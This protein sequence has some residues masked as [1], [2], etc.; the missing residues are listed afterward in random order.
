MRASGGE[1]IP[2]KRGKGSMIYD[3]DGN[4]YIDYV[5]AYGGIIL[6]HAPKAVTHALK[7]S[8]DSGFGFGATHKLEVELAKEIKGAITFIDK[9][10]FTTSGTE[11]VMGALR[12][13][14]G[15]TRRN[16]IVKFEH[17]YHGHADSLLT[18]SGS[19]LASMGLA[20]SEGVPKDFIRHTIIAPY[21]D[22]RRIRDIFKVY[23]SDIAGVII[24]PVGGNYGVTLPNKEFLKY[25]RTITSKYKALLIFDE[26]ITGFRFS[27]GSVAKRLKITPDIICLGKIIG[28]GLP[29]GAYG[30][31]TAIM[32]KLAPLGGVYQASTFS[33]NPIVMQTGIATLNRLKS[34]KKD[35]TQLKE[36]TKYLT[37]KIKESARKSGIKI[38][39]CRYDTI[40]SIRFQKKGLFSKFYRDLLKRGIHLA[41]SQYESN[42]VSFS[43]SKK[44]IEETVKAIDS[45]LRY[46]KGGKV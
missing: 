40:F 3:Y 29:I 43:H 10:R 16:K 19:G 28:G 8:I 25:L 2:I 26:V 41:P 14:R 30:A 13:A 5:L 1:P 4:S 33:G 27:Y 44:E 39:I 6:G 46:I 21:G 34:L 36:M 20:S 31:R 42:F 11:A 32:N 37:D 38:E 35:Y 22:K 18:Q 45:S 7:N 12:L 17:S 23:G 15:F 9:I 24:E